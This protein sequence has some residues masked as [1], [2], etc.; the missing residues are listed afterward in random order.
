MYAGLRSDVTLVVIVVTLLAYGCPVPAIVQ[1]YG[2][3][4]RTVTDWRDRAGRHCERVHEAVVQR[5]QLDLEH[6]QADEMRV[7][8]RQWVAWMG[9]ALMVRTRLWLGGVVQEKRSRPLANKLM[10][11]VHACSKIGCALLLATDGWAAYPKAILRTFRSKVPRQGQVGRC[12]LQVWATLGMVRIVKPT[13][14]AG[15]QVFSLTRQILRGS[16]EFVGQQLTLSHG[17]ILINTAFIERLNA[18]FRQRLALLTRRSRHA[19]K[20]IQ[21]LHAA[22]FLLGTTYNFCAVYFALRQPNFDD[23]AFPP[24]RQQTPAMATG[25]T[26][27]V[28]SLHELLAFRVVPPLLPT[29]KP[30]GRPKK[31]VPIPSTTEWSDTRMWTILNFVT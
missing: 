6:V 20:R 18:T 9:M 24:W 12:Q 22:M 17:G 31:L 2:L 25:L 23:P 27:H 10:Q 28:W 21:T 8:G 19:A 15:K 4:E 29:Q 5:G 13:T 7:K 26:D 1:A 3:D 11:R 30:R 14:E 16:A